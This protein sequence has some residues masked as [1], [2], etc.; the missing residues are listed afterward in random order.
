MNAGSPLV[1]NDNSDAAERK[2]DDFNQLRQAA[3]ERADHSSRVPVLVLPGATR[4]LCS[5]FLSTL[6]TWRPCD[7]LAKQ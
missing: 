4:K 1:N 5:T 2:Q 3:M 6:I 7:R